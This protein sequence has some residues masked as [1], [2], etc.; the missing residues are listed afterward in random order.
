MFVR[1]E[2]RRGRDGTRL[3]FKLVHS[4]RTRSRVRHRGL[5]YLGTIQEQAP[6]EAARRNLWQTAERA[7]ADLD[8]HE[9]QRERLL[10]QLA[11]YVPDEHS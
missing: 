1:V 9:A 10:Q 6:D 3:I 4:E 11:R 7:L 2:K 8:L 5:A